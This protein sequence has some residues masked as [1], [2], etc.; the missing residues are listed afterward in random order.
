MPDV[1]IK[2]TETRRNNNTNS[3][4]H[5]LTRSFLVARSFVIVSSC[6][7]AIRGAAR[8]QIRGELSVERARLTLPAMRLPA[9]A[10]R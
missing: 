5:S 3:L 8:L 1:G 4:T 6:G 2:R 7:G 9:K 10:A